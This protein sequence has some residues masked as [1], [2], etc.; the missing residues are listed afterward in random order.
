MI[1]IVGG[2]KSKE[3]LKREEEIRARAEQVGLKHFKDTYNLDVVFTGY[4]ILPLYVNST[5]FL[6]GY[7]AEEEEKKVDVSIDYMTYEVT[8]AGLPEEYFES[9]GNEKE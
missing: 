6:K 2:C 1:L 4:K 7:I 5:I 9:T 3:E 8:S